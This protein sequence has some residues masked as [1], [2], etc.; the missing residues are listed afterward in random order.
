MWSH[1]YEYR[2]RAGREDGRVDDTPGDADDKVFRSRSRAFW[3]MIQGGVY[4][5]KRPIDPTIAPARNPDG[6]VK[7]D[8]SSRQAAR[9]AS[10]N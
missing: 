4:R 2:I 1:E 3:V 5:A 7:T 8:A 10:M 6:H 9:L